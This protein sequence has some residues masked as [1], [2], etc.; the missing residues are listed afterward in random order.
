MADLHISRRTLQRWLDDLSIDSLEFNDHLK[1]FLTLPHMLRLR[2]YGR[3]MRTR[4]QSLIDRYR[5]ASE[6]D[7]VRWLGRLRKELAGFI[8]DHPS[9]NSSDEIED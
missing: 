8:A 9:K 7:N 6:T 3:F 5:T 4:N 1:V 2:E